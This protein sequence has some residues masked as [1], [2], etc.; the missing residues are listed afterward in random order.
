MSVDLNQN[1]NLLSEK[2]FVWFHNDS[3]LVEI[4]EQGDMTK[5]VQKERNDKWSDDQS[6]KSLCLK[7]VVSYR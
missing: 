5:E 3:I 1:K 4:V 7:P 2:D 6:F